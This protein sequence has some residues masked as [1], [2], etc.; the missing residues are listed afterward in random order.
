M[1]LDQKEEDQLKLLDDNPF[2]SIEACVQHGNRWKYNDWK[3]CGNDLNYVV[4][5]TCDFNG[6]YGW[7]HLFSDSCD[8]YIWESLWAKSLLTYFDFAILEDFL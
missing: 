2:Y 3:K 4:N 7:C 6:N 1:L 8:S 5:V